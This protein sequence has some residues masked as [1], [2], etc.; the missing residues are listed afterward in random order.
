MPMDKILELKRKRA[1]IVEEARE[2]LDKAEK[3]SRPWTE[4]DERKFKELTDQIEGITKAEEREMKLEGYQSV[5]D[6]P[7]I[8]PNPEGPTPSPA[9]SGFRSL[10]E[11]LY[12]VKRNPSD[13]RLVPAEFDTRSGLSEG[14]DT[15]GG[16][17]VPEEYRPQLL[18]MSLESS[19]IRPNGATAIPMSSDTLPIPKV[20]DT[21]HASSLFGGVVAYWTEEKGSL[22]VKEPTFGQVKLIAKTLTGYTYASN[23][24][25][26]DNAV[27]LAA[28]LSRMFGGAL[29]WYEDDAFI[30]GDGVG[31]P[32]GILKSGSL[33]AV[34]RSAASTVAIADLASILAR[35]LP[36]SLGRGV[37]LVNQSVLTQL[38][39]LG[40]TYLTWIGGGPGDLS[41]PFP[42]TLLGRPIFFTEKCSALG[43]AGDI[44]FADLS[45]Y[46]I[47]DREQIAVASSEHVRFTTNETAW[48]FITR[49]DGQPWVDSAF[50]PANGS[51][52]SPFV[53]LYSATTG[54]D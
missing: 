43:T 22:Q 7:V 15:A 14:T 18:L 46:L 30:D 34:N 50:T 11:F 53:T 10:G 49:V 37:W 12:I 17:T 4:E 6:L 47:G 48:R 39:Q 20:T 26:A 36:S 45:Y 40:S 9:K 13:K 38:I 24:L 19:V 51:S 54:G 16:F 23:Q 35:V 5:K 31:K 27:G 2:Y 3:E 52:L 32:L 8:T 41:K 1:L 33:L 44:V 42:A 29:G 21:S 28:L 25:L